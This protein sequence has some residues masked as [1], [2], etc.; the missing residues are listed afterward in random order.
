MSFNILS[1]VLNP[2]AFLNNIIPVDLTAFTNVSTAFNS[3]YTGAAGI[4][5]GL[6]TATQNSSI[7]ISN[8]G[9][10]IVVGTNV[11]G[12]C[13][14]RNGGTS[15]SHITYTGGNSQP[16]SGVAMSGD[17]NY[18]YQ[19]AGSILTNYFRRSSD[20]GVNW[21]YSSPAGTLTNNN[22]RGVN[23]SADG[24][25][26]CLCGVSQ[27]AF[28]VS[29]DYGATFTNISSLVSPICA[30]LS[31]DCNFI[32]SYSANTTSLLKCTNALLTDGSLN[33][34]A[35]FS[36]SG[37]GTLPSAVN[38][39]SISISSSRQYWLVTTNNT[40][41]VYVSSDYGASYVTTNVDPSNTLLRSYGTM[42]PDGSKMIVQFYT[43][44]AYYS[45]DYGVS[46]S[47]IN[48]PVMNTNTS[49]AGCVI[50]RNGTWAGILN[51]T[52]GANRIFIADNV[53]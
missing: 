41:S 40:T 16:S 48:T 20:N 9:Q 10:T 37:M 3:A 19:L 21:T 44:L 4:N 49:W 30:Y 34:S 1:C 35:T 14:S 23:C 53:P 52:T 26:V 47:R 36:S 24:K 12:I 15:W 18:I 32:V 39:L 7:A 46:W 2:I 27:N 38:R 28:R 50:N 25:Y 29:K 22:F 13:I 31:D 42:S 43:G 11:S 8:D 33:T 6:G 51:A 17:G 5:S 45:V